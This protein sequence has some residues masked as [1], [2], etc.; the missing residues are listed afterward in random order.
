MAA[1]YPP[2]LAEL[3]ASK[4]GKFVLLA[5][6]V[7]NA[8][9]ATDVYRVE[10]YSSMTYDEKR[11]RVYRMAIES[12]INDGNTVF[13]EIGPGHDACLTK[14]VLEAD[15]KSTVT[16]I[17]ADALAASG[18]T[19]ALKT[20]GPAGDRWDVIEGRSSD[21]TSAVNDALSSKPFRVILQEILGY[22]ASREGIVRIFADLQQRLPSPPNRCLPGAAATF[23]TPT[24]VTLDLL[25]HN[26]NGRDPLLASKDYLLVSRLPLDTAAQWKVADGAPM[27]GCLE[28]IDFSKPLCAAGDDSSSSSSSSHQLYQ[29]RTQVFK[30]DGTPSAAPRV[31]NSLTLFIWAGFPGK[32]PRR[33]KGN[34]TG[35]PYGCD[36][37]KHDTRQHH[38]GDSGGERQGQGSGHTRSRRGSGAASGAGAASSSSAG[39]STPGTAPAAGGGAEWMVGCLSFSS[40][41]CARDKDAEARNWPNVVLMLPNP[42]SIP[43]GGS[44]EVRSIADL[45]NE[46]CTYAWHVRVDN[47][48]ESMRSSGGKR[49]RKAS[50]SSSSS[51]SAAAKR[52]DAAAGAGAAASAL[53]YSQYS[54]WQILKMDS[55]DVKFMPQQD[56]TGSS[57]SS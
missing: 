26:F 5:S 23:Y 38:D 46:T 42:V 24:F 22:V 11:N 43:P 9:G 57:S 29:D 31:V 10:G 47:G 54:A 45:R 1:Q 19:A 20:F 13:L 55:R 49:P 2:L 39:S 50:T 28:L 27:C 41:C 51:V 37:L 12:A 53:Q 35:F 52:A 21:K 16:A 15:E 44:L 33:V 32:Y 6:F 8:T 17:E 3:L 4:W 34:E 40:A 36:G 18:A 30:Y 56:E 25:R 48:D 7:S 14:M